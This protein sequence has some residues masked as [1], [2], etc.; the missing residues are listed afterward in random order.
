MF[1]GITT[2]SRRADQSPGVLLSSMCDR[3]NSACSVSERAKLYAVACCLLPALSA[4]A[5]DRVT[6]V[7]DPAGTIRRLDYDIDHDDHVD[8]RA[9]LE[10]GRTVRIEADGNGDGMVDRWEYYGTDGHL[11]RL[12][13]SSE[14][15]GL[16]DTWVVQNGDQM[17]VDI[18]TRRDG[19]AD[20]REFHEKG[21]L[22]RA[23]QDTNGDGRTDQW[24]RFADGK[25]RELLIDTSQ[26][27]GR[28]DRRLV[29]ANDGSLE[30]I[31]ADIAPQ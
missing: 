14:S 26:K 30:R 31:D 29:Y 23:E 6:A 18:S 13:T 5:R 1:G 25:L 15:D 8:M 4:C 17:R 16:E 27:T 19:V 20:R 7:Y 12:G 22:V 21:T 11:D 2:A 28:P 3:H 9:Y 24:Q 10:H